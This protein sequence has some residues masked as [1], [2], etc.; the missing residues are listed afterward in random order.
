MKRDKGYE[1][2][3]KQAEYDLETAKAMFKSGRY[4]YVVF[5]SHLSIEKIL[6]ALFLKKLKNFPPKTH[7]LLY[8]IEKIGLDIPE[9]LYS[10]IFMLNRVSVPTRYPEDLSKM[11]KEFNKRRAEKILKNTEEVFLWIKEKLKK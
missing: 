1:E 3:L 9:K 8:L 2:W 7:N 11:L 10:F 6:K 5:M 4:I